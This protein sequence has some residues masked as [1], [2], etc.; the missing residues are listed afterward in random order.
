[1]YSK[2]YVCALE[3]YACGLLCKIS[4]G[5][6]GGL[7]F[8]MARLNTTIDDELLKR[9]K[10]SG[11]NL[12]KGVFKRIFE[13]ALEEQLSNID[14]KKFDERLIKLTQK[15]YELE[16]DKKD[17]HRR[18]DFVVKKLTIANNNSPELFK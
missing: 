15:I 11:I 14:A 2:C 5:R 1:M 17:M 18:I 12:H 9:L 3:I 13:E 8:S 4:S 6:D 10:L 16:A 7:S